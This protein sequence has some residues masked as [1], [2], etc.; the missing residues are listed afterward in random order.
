MWWA[1][2]D[3][4]HLVLRLCSAYGLYTISESPTL[5][6]PENAGRG[7]V[8][9]QKESVRLPASLLVKEAEDLPVP[10]SLMGAPAPVQLMLAVPSAWALLV[11]L[12]TVVSEAGAAG[13]EPHAWSHAS[14]AEPCASQGMH[15]PVCMP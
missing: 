11:V 1:S 4:M 5:R 15:K 14:H 10:Y 6:T 7:V 3:Q 12:T 9:G 13:R 8:V 2:W